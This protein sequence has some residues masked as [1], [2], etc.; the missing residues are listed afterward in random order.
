MK[1]F[2]IGTLVTNHAQYATMRASFKSAGFSDDSTHYALI[3]NSNGNIADAYAG[4]RKLL[5]DAKTPYVILCHQDVEAIDTRAH[6]EACIAE[7]DERDARWGVAGNAGGLGAKGL[8]I[9]ISDPNG[10]DQR[11]GGPFPKRVVSLDENFLLIK[12]ETGVTF[13]ADLHGFHLYG[14]DV[15]LIAQTLG[16]SAYVIDY[17]LKHHGKATMGQPFWACHAAFEKKWSGVLQGRFIKTTCTHVQVSGSPLS[18]I[19]ANIRAAVINTRK[20]LKRQGRYGRD[21]LK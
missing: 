7:L 21:A 16:F 15:C 12:R 20:R 13:S 1:T 6:L 3:D 5:H 8:A 4:L 17:H 14:T 10:H 2:T 9:R 11:R 19:R 18:A